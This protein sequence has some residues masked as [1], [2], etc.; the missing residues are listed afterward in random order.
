VKELPALRGEFSL[1][2]TSRLKSSD[3]FE[4]ADP[5]GENPAFMF[6]D[7]LCEDTRFATSHLFFSGAPPWPISSR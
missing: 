2:D 6:V 5:L 4:E 1:A 7:Q 3:L